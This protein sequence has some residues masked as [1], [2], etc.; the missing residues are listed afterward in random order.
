MSDTPWRLRCNC[1]QEHCCNSTLEGYYKS[2]S[3]VTVVK[4]SYG[5]TF[6]VGHFRSRHLHTPHSWALYSYLTPT[7][8][9]IT[10]TFLHSNLMDFKSHQSCLSWKRLWWRRARNLWRK[11]HE[12]NE[13]SNLGAL[14]FFHTWNLH[15]V[16][17][18]PPKLL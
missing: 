4:H 10:P 3:N 5:S 7:R 9:R 8:L 15:Y 12:K 17:I 2:T 18:T 14:F 1:G 16:H 13:P 6:S 11:C